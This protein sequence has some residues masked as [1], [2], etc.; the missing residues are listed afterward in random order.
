MVPRSK[1]TSSPLR[2][3]QQRDLSRK[4]WVEAGLHALVRGGVKSVAVE[5]LATKLK[6]TKGSFYWHF[7][8]R[9]ELLDEMLAGWME[10]NT[11]PF[12]A[13]VAVDTDKPLLQFRRFSEIWLDPNGFDSRL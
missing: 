13:V 5:R 12:E 11:K 3:S 8:D 9:D 1:P 7:R 4:D 10:R 2:T 6:V